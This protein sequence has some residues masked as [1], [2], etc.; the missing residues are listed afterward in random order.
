MKKCIAE[1]ARLELV[2]C[3]GAEQRGG[4]IK[5]KVRGG[6]T[7]NEKCKGIKASSQ[8]KISSQKPRTLQIN[9]LQTISKIS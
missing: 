6:G 7:R 3:V 2:D 4:V 5:G 8:T 1:F 9:P